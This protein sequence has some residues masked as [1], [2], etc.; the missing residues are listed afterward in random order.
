[1]IFIMSDSKTLEKIANALEKVPIDTNNMVMEMAKSMSDTEIIR[2]FNQ[3][4]LDFFGA[5]IEITRSLGKLKECGFEAYNQFLHIAIKTDAKMPIDQFS[6]VVLEF[7]PSI[8]REDEDMFLGMNIPDSQM[9]GQFA[10]NEF[11]IIRSDKF[12]NLWRSLSDAHKEEIKTHVINLTIS[13]HAFFYQNIIN[14]K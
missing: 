14:Y 13:A 5:L 6:V 2:Q 10:N 1:M 3:Y 9:H 8:Y 4:S 11:S 7:A 12:K